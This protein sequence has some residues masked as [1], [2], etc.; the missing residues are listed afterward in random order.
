MKQ[1]VPISDEL[2]FDHP[3]QIREPLVPFSHEYDCYHPLNSA[4]SE[5]TSDKDTSHEK[6]NN[7]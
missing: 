6:N 3:E 1:F 5:H 4:A 7:R 2:I